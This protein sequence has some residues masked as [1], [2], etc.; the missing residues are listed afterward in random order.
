M[1]PKAWGSCIAITKSNPFRTFWTSLVTLL[2]IYIGTIFIYRLCFIDFRIPPP[3]DEDSP[4]AAEA[5][6]QTAWDVFDTI[7]TI[8]FWVDLVTGPSW[9]RQ[10]SQLRDSTGTRTASAP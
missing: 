8:A 10:G 4:P 9:A 6:G 7:V 3:S 5:S 1:G 2:L